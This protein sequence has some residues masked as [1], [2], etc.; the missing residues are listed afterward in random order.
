MWSKNFDISSS[1]TI[2]SD[3]WIGKKGRI[4]IT[5]ICYTQDAIIYNLNNDRIN[6][7]AKKYNPGTVG[8]DAFTRLVI[9]INI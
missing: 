9:F 3:K 2:F 4:F 7:E 1:D 8:L 6:T 5:V